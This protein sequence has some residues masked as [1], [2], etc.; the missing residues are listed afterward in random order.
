M[1]PYTRIFL[2]V[3]VQFRVALWRATLLFNY[4]PSPVNNFPFHICVSENFKSTYMN[5]NLV[6]MT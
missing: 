4:Q 2:M 3:S 6:S 5:G 1:S